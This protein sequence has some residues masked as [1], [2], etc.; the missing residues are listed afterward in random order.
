AGDLARYTADL[1]A[2]AASDLDAAQSRLAEL[3]RLQRL[4]GP[5]L[6]DVIDWARTQRPRL[7]ELQGDSG[8]LE[9]L[10][11]EV[12]RLD[13]A[14]RERAATLTALRTAAAE[15]LETAVTE[16]LHALFMPDASFHVG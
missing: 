12:D 9:E 4:Y 3:T 13:A 11:A 8:R 1:D 16:E 14:L 5:E 10:E 15:R 2:D 7:D 6:A